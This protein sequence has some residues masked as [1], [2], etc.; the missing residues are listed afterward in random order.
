MWNPT[1]VA[2]QLTGVASG[3]EFLHRMSLVHGNIRGVSLSTTTANSGPV[4]KVSTVKHPNQ[5]QPAPTG[6][7]RGLRPEHDP[8]PFFLVD[9]R[10]HRLDRTGTFDSR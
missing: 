7:S 4:L 10:A 8:L 9:Q 5:R 1:T 6:P 3:L 2:S